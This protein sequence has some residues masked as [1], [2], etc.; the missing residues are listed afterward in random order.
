MGK[1]ENKQDGANECE[2]EESV[3]ETEVENEQE[4]MQA[5]KIEG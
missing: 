5:K 3:L 1:A 4:G 2:M